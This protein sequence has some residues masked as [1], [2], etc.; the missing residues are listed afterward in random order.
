MDRNAPL[1]VPVCGCIYFELTL[2]H[3]FFLPCAMVGL[4]ASFVNHKW[5]SNIQLLMASHPGT[6]K[7][8]DILKN[9]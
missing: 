1:D 2:M 4:S 5:K 6:A 3:L 8:R 7:H 9:L